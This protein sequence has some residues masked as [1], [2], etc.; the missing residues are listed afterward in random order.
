MDEEEDNIERLK[1]WPSQTSLPKNVKI[2]NEIR[3][4]IAVVLIRNPEGLNQHKLN[5]LFTNEFGFGIHAGRDC[6]CSYIDLL[7]LLDGDILEL[8]PNIQGQPPTIFPSR[9]LLELAKSMSNSPDSKNQ[10]NYF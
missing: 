5:Q 2:P 7:R 6:N 3:L 4:R 10:L 1:L 8:R 9:K